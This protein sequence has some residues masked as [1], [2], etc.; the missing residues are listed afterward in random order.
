M[1]LPGVRS[2]NGVAPMMSPMAAAENIRRTGGGDGHG[3]AST[4][5]RFEIQPTA[6]LAASLSGSRR[7]LAGSQ[8]SPGLRRRRAGRYGWAATRGAPLTRP[9]HAGA[10]RPGMRA[11]PAVPRHTLIGRLT[12][13]QTATDRHHRPQRAEGRPFGV[14]AVTVI[15]N[16]I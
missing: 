10:T 7:R 5:K 1:V 6:R 13:P 16:P 8:T 9:S 4:V 3:H 11:S 14:A 12:R 15:V 2:S